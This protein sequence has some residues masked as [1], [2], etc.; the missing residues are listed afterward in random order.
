MPSV[1]S[2]S[3]KV[4]PLKPGVSQHRALHARLTARDFFFANFYPS[5]PSIHLHFFSKTSPEF[6]FPVLAAANTGSCVGPQNKIGH[7]MQVPV[8]SVR[9][10]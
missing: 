3:L 2:K 5:S 6:F 8:L 9:G 4:L 7:S 1:E 10:I